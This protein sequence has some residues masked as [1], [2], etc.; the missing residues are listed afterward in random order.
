LLSAPANDFV[1]DFVGE[2]AALKRLSL[3]RVAD[4]ELRDWPTVRA[5]ADPQEVRTLLSGS[6]RSAVLVLDADGKPLRRVGADHLRRSDGRPLAEV[7]L[8]PSAKVEA[9]ATLSDALNE[10]ITARYSATI[11][12]D[13]RGRYT[14]VV[15]FDQIHDA[16]R[17]MRQAAVD[18]AR[19]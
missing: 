6:T 2:G 5:D 4:I 8:Q 11:V 12:V 14:G 3:N 7:G 9:R 13:D 1:S 17:G 15:E 16:I 19:S 18:R 10:L